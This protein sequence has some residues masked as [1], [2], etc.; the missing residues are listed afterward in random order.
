[1]KN[2]VILAVLG[3][4]AA[5]PAFAGN[6][7]PAPVEAPVIAP[8][9]MAAPAPLVDWTGFYAGAQAGY[10]FG[11]VG[12]T[13]VEGIVGGLHAGYNYDFGR[14]VLGSEL[15]YNFGDVNGGGDTI[16]QLAHLKAK[17]GFK[18]GKALVYGTAGGAYAS[19][20]IG[21]SDLS[22][23]GWTA[24]AGV[25][26]QVRPNIIAGVEYQYSQF[27]DF[28]SSGSDVTTNQISAKVSYKF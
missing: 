24:G 4:G 9:P 15:D 10:G 21:G 19:G 18:V 25:D 5:A 22:D 7:A 13:D 16:D 3:L 1:M 23:F 11:D 8:A 28:D 26:Y 2:S 20:D 27:D 17:G 14:F 6:L 12:G